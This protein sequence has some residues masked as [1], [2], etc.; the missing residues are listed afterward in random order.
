MFQTPNGFWRSTIEGGINGF[1]RLYRPEFAAHEIHITAD[2]PPLLGRP[3]LQG[4][5]FM[6]RYLQEI[7]DATGRS[8]NLNKSSKKYEYVIISKYYK[9][10]DSYGI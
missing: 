7:E 9:E 4:V 3:A 2:Y 6:E 10:S 8:T 5:E 1:F